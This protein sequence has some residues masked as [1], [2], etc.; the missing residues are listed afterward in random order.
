MAAIAAVAQIFQHPTRANVSG[1]VDHSVGGS[2]EHDLD[3][4]VKHEVGGTVKHETGGSVVHKIVGDCLSS[5]NASVAQS[6]SR[7]AFHPPV[8]YQ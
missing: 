7:N 6:V 1:S 8:C 2:V 3:G 5:D 4:T